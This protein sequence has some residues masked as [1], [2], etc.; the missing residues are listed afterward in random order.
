[1]EMAAPTP[2]TTVADAMNRV[3]EAERTAAAAIKAA[4]AEAESTLQAARETRRRLLERARDRASR[5]HVRAQARLA[6][7]IA[8]LDARTQNGRGE[9]GAFDAI[10][11]RAI[12]NL[13]R[14]LTSA[15][16]EPS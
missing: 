4:E 13:A 11:Q 14:R 5:I 9:R 8:E 12:D 7:A 16:H 15:D 6:A 1:M 10:A 3:L 2:D